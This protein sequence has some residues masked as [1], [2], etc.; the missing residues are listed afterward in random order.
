MV[1]LKFLFSNIWHFIALGFG[2]GL[3]KKGT[4][5]FGTLITFIYF[6]FIYQLN[7]EIQI[8]IFFILLLVSYI[9]VKNTLQ[10]LKI[11]D[12][13]CVVI[14]EIIAYLIVLI[15]LPNNYLLY[16]ISF[17]L[18]RFFDILKPWPIS[19][20]E[21]LPGAIGVIADDFGAALFALV[22]TQMVSSYVL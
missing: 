5:T 3:I 17:I 2:A 22:I 19:K 9:S 11:K 16:L 15:L 14:D 6:I 18:F 8:L 21:E 10:S 20:L 4:G 1:N 7:L 12:P 13:S